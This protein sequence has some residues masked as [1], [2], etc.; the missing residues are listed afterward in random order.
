MSAPTAPWWRQRRTL[1]WLLLA[2]VLAFAAWL[3]W[4]PAEVAATQLRSQPLT[5][6][7][8]FTARVKTPARV[9][10]GSTVTGRVLTVA[11]NEG[12]QVKAGAA[13]VQLEPD[14]ARANLLQAQAS[15]VQ[16]EA[17]LA[18]QQALALPNAQAALAQAEANLLAAQRE[19][20]RSK[21]L[22]AAQFY[23]PQK[24]D[25]SQRALDVARAQRD[26]A[27]AQVQANSQGGERGAAQ[28]QVAS[29]R[30]AV[31][32]AQAKL[33]QT[34]LRAPAAGRVLLRTVEPGQ[35]VQA[36][37]ALLTLAVRGRTELVAD[38]DER[39][40][41]QLQV[42]QTARVLADAYPTQ[43]FSAHVDRLG[44][45]VDAQ[46]G[47]VEVTFVL[48]GAAPAFL[49]E[50]MTL[51]TEVTTGRS[52]QARVLPLRALREVANAARPEQGSVLVVQNG[53]A[54]VRELKLGLRTLDQAEVLSGLGEG[55]VV[56]LDATL[57]PGSRVRAALTRPTP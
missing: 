50:D 16:A 57:A 28:A 25:E 46:A 1:W 37:K 21:E 9:E 43:P 8:Q 49:R 14:E 23:S 54:V 36:G 15:L 20:A 18:S 6:T 33:D 22:V 51:S 35:I 13:L 47:S 40:L 2:L 32:V 30:A 42:G 34:T 5:R 24:L 55:D 45:A 52:A 48:D 10:L 53:R 26:A 29:A 41:A 19:L 11:V 7:L 56:L 39:F 12:D 4:R 44:A 3:R 27:R 17:R 31:E 38:V